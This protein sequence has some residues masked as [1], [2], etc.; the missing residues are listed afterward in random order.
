MGILNSYRPKGDGDRQTLPALC[1]TPDKRPESPLLVVFFHLLGA[2]P[3]PHGFGGSYRKRPRDAGLYTPWPRPLRA[4]PWPR[5]QEG[6]Q[7]RQAGSS[8]ELLGPLYTRPKILIVLREQLW[9][10]AISPGSELGI[11]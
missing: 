8:S 11:P 7:I 5:P 2:P 6:P 3:S 1:A 10:V 9:A 4:A